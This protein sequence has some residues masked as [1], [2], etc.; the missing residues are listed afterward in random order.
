MISRRTFVASG[1]A[2]LGGIPLAGS[3]G[4]QDL[5]LPSTMKTI[6]PFPPGTGADIVVR[7]YA[8]ALQ[9]RSGKT[10][11]V[12]NRPGAFGNIAVEAIARSKPDGT[13][14]GIVPSS[15]IAA[16]PSL[17]KTVS[18]DPLG[19]FDQVATLN[20][21]PWYLV[22]AGDSPHQSVADLVAQLKKLGDK[23]SYASVA[24]SGLIS[25]ELFKVAFGLQT[26]EVKYKETTAMLNDLWGGNVA[27]AHLDPV[28]ALAHLKSGKLR[29]LSSST[30]ERT[31][32][33]PNI[34]SA[35]ESGI[36]NCDLAGWWGIAMPKGTPQ[37]IRDQLEKIFVAFVNSAEHN[38][39]ITG[40]GCDPFPG[41]H[42]VAQQALLREI[43]LWKKYVDL[44]KIEKI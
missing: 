25:S 18:Y 44:A 15:A 40:I 29:A 39:F 24:N 26:V 22:V 3:A 31:K 7:F 17:F 33:F 38:D 1:M 30:K 13:T 21:V 28:S 36:P 2:A 37:P 34:P 8:K 43:D 35:A 14:V 6:C 23:G 10:V 42:H 4:A 16:A 9:D 12:E 27:F 41:D 19:D 20:R 32:T 5:A 11:I